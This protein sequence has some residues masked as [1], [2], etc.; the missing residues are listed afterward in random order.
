MTEEQK[1][2]YDTI[3]SSV[4]D[5]R[6]GLFFL[7]GYGGIVASIGISPL[8]NLGGRI[9]LSRFGMPIQIIENFT[10]R[11]K[12]GDPLVELIV[13]S[14]LIIWD[15][16]PM[17]HKHSFEVV[18]KMFRDILR[19]SNLRSMKVPFRGKVVV[20][21]GDFRQI[22]PVIPKG[23]RQDIVHASINFSYLWQFCRVL[24]LTKNTRLKSTSSCSNLNNV[25]EFSS[26][27]LNVGD[28]N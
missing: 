13:R 10:C 16:A 4:N 21:D 14:K 27:I 6:G 25:K 23:T 9:T 28:G 18:D 12:L 7:Y 15:E 2:I 17:I 8:L 24:T 3:I 22:L 19:V 20:L 26:W 11:I 5:N 1:N